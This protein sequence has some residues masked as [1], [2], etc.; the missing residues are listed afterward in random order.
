MLEVQGEPIEVQANG[1]GAM[2]IVERF[3][4]PFPPITYL[5]S[6]LLRTFKLHG[7]HG[8]FPKRHRSLIGCCRSSNL[9]KR[10]HPASLQGGIVLFAELLERFEQEP[11]ILG[12]SVVE[13][14]FE[15]T[16][17]QERSGGEEKD[18]FHA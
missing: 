5:S 13:L 8:F 4:V 14:G 17:E 1:I 2:A 15:G 12:G 9:L 11:G 18:W 6:F 7:F 3:A 16:C 10:A